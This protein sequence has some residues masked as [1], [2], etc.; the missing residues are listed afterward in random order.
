MSTFSSH[1]RD[2]TIVTLALTD[3]YQNVQVSKAATHFTFQIQNESRCLWRRSSTDTGE[4]TVKEGQSYAIPSSLGTQDGA[5]ITIGQI[6]V[7]A[8]GGTDTLE[9]WL[10]YG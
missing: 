9:I 5:T 8:T 3:A 7:I 10:W 1:G 6:K 4:W 2:Y